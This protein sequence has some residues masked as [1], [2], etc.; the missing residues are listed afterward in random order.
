MEFLAGYHRRFPNLRLPG[1]QFLQAPQAGYVDLDSP[2]FLA[3]AKKRGV[4]ALWGFRF[5]N[6]RH[7]RE[8]RQKLLD[9][10]AFENSWN[11]HFIR[12]FQRKSQEREYWLCLHIR[13]GDFRVW[14]GG[15][16][17]LSPEVFARAA[18]EIFRAC[19]EKKIRFWV[20]SDEPVN[21]DFFP[22]GTSRTFGGSLREDFQIMVQSDGL[23]LGKSTLGLVAAYLA[24]ARYWCLL[25]GVPPKNPDSWRDGALAVEE[26]SQPL[27]S[28]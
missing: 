7:V 18:W 10:L 20:C 9:F 19:P 26:P 16:W 17:Y 6:N 15:S 22:P 27:E 4:L 1:L 25:D 5:R 14:R 11:P 8:Q 24:G 2:E 23:L 28:Q 3:A 21:L 13:Q 12:D